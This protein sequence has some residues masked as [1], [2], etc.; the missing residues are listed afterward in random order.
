MNAVTHLKD[1]KS[2]EYEGL[3][4]DRFIHGNRHLYVLFSILFTLFSI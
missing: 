3:S 4:T 1:G 2:D